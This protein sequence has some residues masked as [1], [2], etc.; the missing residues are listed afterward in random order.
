M[1]FGQ[2]NGGASP[3]THSRTHARTHTMPLDTEQTREKEVLHPS[4]D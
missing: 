4:G 2:R 1:T 3:T